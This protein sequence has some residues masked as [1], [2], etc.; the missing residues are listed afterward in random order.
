MFKYEITEEQKKQFASTYLL[1]YMINTPK[2]FPVFLEG[3]S[4]DLEPVLE[5]LM[6]QKCIEIKDKKLYIPTKKGREVLVQFRKRYQ[7]FLKNFDIFCAVDLEEGVFAFED[8]LDYIEKPQQWEIYLQEERWEDLRVAVAKL[9][10]LNPVEI[11]FMSFLNEGRYGKTESGWEFD[12]LLGSIWDEIAEICENALKIDD[13]AF[14]DEEGFV[15]GEDVLQDI[16]AQAAELNI[17][18]AKEAEKMDAKAAEE[19]IEYYEDEPDDEY[20]VEEV[21]IEDLSYDTYY[22]YRDP[23]YVSPIWLILLF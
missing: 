18:L 14:E 20:Y 3:N 5:Y 11:V 12:L 4:E 7:D 21:I 17:E 1:N 8:Y 6:Q 19:E 16:M 9:K 2:T 15:S 13:L 23:Y 10:G 22:G